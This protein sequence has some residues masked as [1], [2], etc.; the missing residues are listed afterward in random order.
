[1]YL[2]KDWVQ[3]IN[4]FW[5]VCLGIN[6]DFEDVLGLIREW[7]VNRRYGNVLWR[8]GIIRMEIIWDYWWNVLGMCEGVWG[9]G[10]EKMV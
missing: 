7:L 2:W 4:R 8:Y 9:D 10:R 6:R 3:I 1:M 5:C